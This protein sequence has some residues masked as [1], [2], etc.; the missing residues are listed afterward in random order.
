MKNIL[1]IRLPEQAKHKVFWLVYSEA[2]QQ[3]HQQG[4]LASMEQL[5][6]LRTWS[7]SCDIY[8]AAAGQSVHLFHIE[9]P[10]QSKRHADKVIPYML[11]DD[12]SQ[13]LQ[14]V[15]FAW[16]VHHTESAL[17]VA[18]VAH[19]Q[20]QFWT[21]A[22]KQAGLSYQAIIPD[23]L[24]LPP[25]QEQTWSLARIGQSWVV[26]YQAWQGRTLDQDWLAYAWDAQDF[27][28]EEPDDQAHFPTH[29]DAYGL[30]HES[31][32]YENA[33]YDD[34][35]YKSIEPPAPLVYQK[36]HPLLIMAQHCRQAQL[37]LA[38]GAYRV[39]T[40]SRF[41]QWHWQ[42]LAWAAS[43]LLVVYF[44]FLWGTQF[45]MERDILAM[46]KAMEQGYL[47]LFPEQKRLPPDLKKR[48]EQLVKT[49]G[50]DQQLASLFV[51]L[52]LAFEGLDIQL[53]VLQYDA[54]R[55]E[56]KVQASGK[57]FQT[58]ER[59]KQAAQA[60]DFDVEQGQMISRSGR[61]AGTLTIR[62]L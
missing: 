59:F 46:Q 16:P 18:V 36:E 33:L 40:P 1:I 5:D 42:P 38:Q 31:S 14:E 24:L 26:Q 54:S 55:Q 58:F 41:G 57:N 21:Q 32:A 56:L 17:P 49:G 29:I 11:E 10:R 45:Q 6:Q 47:E 25:S 52:G 34:D 39:Q 28:R 48:M 53:S 51:S 2:E 3:V 4:E 8:I 60:L 12:I 37:N 15:H 50:G 61:I 30:S 62:N 44:G 20:M 22:L 9:L 35:L 19:Q 7:E 27:S 43:A 23:F 13:E